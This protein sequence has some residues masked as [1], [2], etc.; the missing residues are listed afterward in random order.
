MD[1]PL[2]RFLN[3]GLVEL[4]PKLGPI[5]W[6]FMPFKKFEREDF[7]G[8]LKLLPREL[9]G[10]PLRHVMDVRHDSFCTPEYLARTARELADEFGGL[11]AVV[12]VAGI[13]RPTS[14]GKGSDDDWRDILSV[15]LDGY[16]NVLT[17][18]LPL[19]AAA[20]IQDNLMTASNDLERL[21]RLLSDASDALLGAMSLRTTRKSTFLSDAYYLSMGFAVPAAIAEW[22]RTL[23]PGGIMLTVF[24]SHLEHRRALQRLVGPTEQLGRNQKFTVTRTVLD[25]ANGLMQQLTQAEDTKPA[26]VKKSAEAEQGG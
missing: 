17:A 15:H 10:L 5:L 25:K 22:Y 9:K 8:F 23:R 4:G 26:K 7:A 18:A 19:M 14:F 24:N 20:D 21:Q 12:N 2:G 1:E 11:D 16:L 6:Q 3:Q 13:T